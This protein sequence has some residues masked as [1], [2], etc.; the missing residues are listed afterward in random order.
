MRKLLT[1]AAALYERVLARKLARTRPIDVDAHVIC[2]GNLTVGGTGK[3][4]VVAALRAR[5]AATGTRAASL[6]RGYGG[7]LKGPLKVDRHLHTAANVGDEPLMLAHGGEAWIGRDRIEAARVMAA[8]GVKAIVMDDGHQSP[9]LARHLSLVVIDSADPF[10]NGYVLPKGP[11]REP[12]QSGLV[13][14]DA[15]LLAGQGD[16]PEAVIKSG[17][18]VFRFHLAPLQAVPTG[19]LF[20][21]AGIGRPQKFFDA[22]T[23]HGAILIDGMAFDDHHAYTAHDI[24]LLEDIARHHRAQLITTEKDHVRLPPDIQRQV[25]VFPVAA[26]FEND[27]GLDALITAALRS[28]HVE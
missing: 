27:T 24:D 8:D 10:G 4:P 14:A 3:T 2:V 19:P 21:F 13:R 7:R 20:A 16:V 18:P 17:K 6:S 26:R 22:L 25:L 28:A 12:I 1:P 11:L 5:L 15:V 23:A 9:A